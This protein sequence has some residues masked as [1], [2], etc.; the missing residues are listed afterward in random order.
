MPKVE[1]CKVAFVFLNFIQINK[2]QFLIVCN[3][4]ALPLL[5]C[6]WEGE[7]GIR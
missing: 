4:F 1:I 2:I 3:C 5:S 6:E 7:S